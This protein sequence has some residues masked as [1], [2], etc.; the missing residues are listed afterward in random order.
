MSLRLPIGISDFRE[1]REKGLTYVD[2]SGLLI[3]MIDRLGTK[4]L[5]LPRPR[6]F[7][8]TL[9]LSM[10]RYFFE[11]QPEDLSHLF[12]GLAVWE[13]GETYREHFQR[14]PVIFITFRDVK[15][16]SFEQCRMDIE[17]KI[18]ALFREH[19]PLLTSGVL[20]ESEA[21]D[22]QAILDAT[23]EPT[24]YRRALGDLSL[25][26]HRAT[27][28]RAVILIDEYDEPIHA[29][30]VNG[31]GKEIIDFFRH[32][33]TVGLKDNTHLERGVVTGILRI[34]R[35]SIF[36]GLN[37]L[38][39]CTLLEPAFSTCF[40]FTEPEVVSLLEQ[41]GRSDRLEEARIWYNGYVFGNTVIYNPWSILNFL[42]WGGATKPYWLNTSSN[43]LIKKLLEGRT[44]QLQEIFE[45]LLEGGGIDKIIDEN[46]VLDELET[47]DDALWS[48][49]LFS[50]YLKAEPRARKASWLPPSSFLTIPNNEVRLLYVGTFAHWMKARMQGHGGHLDRLIQAL[51]QG[52]AGALEKQLGAFVKNILSY[53]D[54]D[55]DEPERIYQAFLL[56]L[57]AA[58]EPEH[59][60][61]SN[62]ESGKGRPDVMLLPLEPGQPGVILELKVA[63]KNKSLE[64]VL[65][66]G[67]KQVAANDYEA[68]LRAAGAQPIHVF[69]CAFDGKEV[70]VTTQA[71]SP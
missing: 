22:Y 52:D 44:T 58:V 40:G 71:S 59:R 41:A 18:Q 35:E 68:E 20:R 26:L 28:E 49:L 66:E 4:V 64:D 57:C 33:L 54:I 19:E 1:L 50:G 67:L 56:G 39:V 45:R 6:R 38:A 14:Y 21:R 70:R 10:L 7:G 34:A 51:L 29:G 16:T 42:A 8:K 32:F 9:N 5:L 30:H 11:K 43:D 31:Y 12:E 27:G 37:N 3:E 36:S 65:D 69:V 24:L 48:L 15:A 60:V 62:R 55:P 25:Y 13:A 63:R 2:K 17:K 23:A 47:N 46:V 61:R 53:H